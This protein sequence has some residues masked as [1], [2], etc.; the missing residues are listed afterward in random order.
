MAS[1]NHDKIERTLTVPSLP[2]EEMLDAFLRE[3]ERL[4]VKDREVASDL[5]MAFYF[6]EDYGRALEILT[7]APMSVA[8]EWF[9]AELLYG[10]RRFIEAMEH[11]NQLEVKYSQ[12][13]E[14]TFAVSYL[15]ARCLKESG[16]ATIALE[17]LQGIVRV[18][19]NYRSVNA[20]LQEW[21]EGATW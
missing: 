21:T 15:R 14:T 2:D 9:K 12:D 1:L 18:R 10:A 5:A 11:L 4:A 17:I 16:Q 20:L 6:M 7:W 8:N 3:G 19:P 13:P